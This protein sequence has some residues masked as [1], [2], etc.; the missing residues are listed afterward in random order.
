M[1]TDPLNHSEAN[2]TDPVGFFHTVHQAFERAERTAGDRVDRFYKIGGHTVRLRF[3][4]SALVPLIVP[5]LE[6]LATQASSAPAL[7]ICL[8]D[9]DSTGM[10]KPPPPPWSWGEYAPRGELHGY[11]DDR[12]PPPSH[13]SRLSMLALG[14]DL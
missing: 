5:A 2:V 12:I 4:G 10:E 13:A 6:H 8:W 9:S 3:A 7:T 14:V 11:N 1:P